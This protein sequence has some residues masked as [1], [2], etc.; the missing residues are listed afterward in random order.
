MAPAVPAVAVEVAG[1][2]ARSLKLREG[3]DRTRFEVVALAAK[4]LAYWGCALVARAKDRPIGLSRR[5]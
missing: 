3:P 1:A 2:E 4:P 5:P